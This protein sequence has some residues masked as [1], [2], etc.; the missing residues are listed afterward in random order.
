M[1]TVD[2]QLFYCVLDALPYL[3]DYPYECTEQT[4]NRFLSTG[5]VSGALRRLPGGGAD[6]A[7]SSPSARRRFETWDAADPNRKMAL[8]ETP[9][10]RTAAGRRRARPTT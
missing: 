10:L 6:G 8:E 9:W 2:A 4:L 1:V 5:I 7:R 3:V